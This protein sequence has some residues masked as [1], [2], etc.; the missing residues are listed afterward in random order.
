MKT[1]ELRV[2]ITTHVNTHRRDMIKH[3]QDAIRNYTCDKPPWEY[4]IP[5]L[6]E[7][8][9]VVREKKNLQTAE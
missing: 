7:T 5:S 3:V 2:T 4:P 9:S 8:V 6:I 1:I